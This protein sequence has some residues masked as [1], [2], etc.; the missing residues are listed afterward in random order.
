MAR[1][2]ARMIGAARFNLRTYEEVEA[3]TG[4]NAQALAVVFLACLGAGIGWTGLAPER[5]S[6]GFVL[7]G[8]AVT[9]WVT[10]AGL[11]YL[12]GTRLLPEPQTRADLGELLRTLGFAQAPGVLQ[13]FGLVPGLSPVAVT[14]VL[15]L[16]WLATT[17]VAVRQALDFTS[18]GRAVAVCVTGWALALIMFVVIGIV[19]APTVS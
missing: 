11:T 9:G 8:V 7:V 10:W 12:I 14:G 4:A 19:S 15:A 2:V 5:W 17:V 3:D 1:F 16:W 6:A 18:T 13:V